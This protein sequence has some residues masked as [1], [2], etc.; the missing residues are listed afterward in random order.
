MAALINE[1]SYRHGLAN[2]GG[3]GSR[4]RLLKNVMGL[5]ILQECR[6]SGRSA[7]ALMSIPEL[8]RLAAESDWES[9]LF[10]PDDELFYQPGP[11]PE[12]IL[13]T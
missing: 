3:V 12:L 8:V 4:I 11:M 10:D 5:W 9:G 13:R 7:E 1:R 6:R 2:E